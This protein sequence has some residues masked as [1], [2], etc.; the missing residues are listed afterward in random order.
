LICN[1][2]KEILFVS[3]M[4]DGKTHDFAIFKNIFTN[5]DFSALNLYVDLGF[6]GIKKTI[7]YNELFIPHKASKNHPLNDDQKKENSTLSSV[8]VAVENAIAKLKSFFILRIENRMRINTKLDDA[9]II[10]S[11]LANFKTKK[12]KSLIIN[13]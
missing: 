11:A 6:L 13:M 4:Y 5:I 10:C 12:H 2:K 8:R 9:F 1:E 7:K 3:P